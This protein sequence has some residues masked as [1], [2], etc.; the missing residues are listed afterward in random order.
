MKRFVSLLS[1]AVAAALLTASL[2]PAQSIFP[3]FPQ[4]TSTIPSNGDVNPYGVVIVPKTIQAG[5]GLNPGA[6][7][8]SNF[9]NN[10]NLQGTGTTII[11]VTASGAVSTFYTSSY[12]RVGLTAALGVLSNGWVIVGNLPTAD[13]TPA[14]VQPG[15][16]SVLS[17]GGI[18]LGTIG[19]LATVDGPWGM[20]V[21]D[22]GSAGTGTAHVFVSNVLSGTISRFDLT[23]TPSNVG[24]T[25]ITLAAGFNHRTD[26]AAL[27]LGPSGLAYDSIHNQL[28]V[29]SSTD[30]AVY[31]IPN[32]ATSSTEQ[33]ATLLFSDTTHLHGPLDIGFLPNGHLLVADSDGSNVDPN[34]PSEIVEYTAAGEFVGQM[35]ID[36]NN[37]GAFGLAIQNL[38]WGTFQLAAVDDNAV[39]LRVWTSVI[40]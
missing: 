19:T 25:V 15:A 32:A 37:G 34:Q 20:A 24:A 16:L 1:S 21:D 33:S 36:P 12:P 5:S 35:P 9:N 30:N 7:L 11:R 40:P 14:T 8:V 2:A 22:L 3:L 26:P 13:G 4:T 27:V 10:Q 17:P 29:A 23:Y 18:F 31:A 6:I 28:L 38:G 39:T